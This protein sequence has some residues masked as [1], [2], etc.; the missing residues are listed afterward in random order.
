[1]N[2]I[3]FDNEGTTKSNR[4]IHT[5]SSFARKNLN[6]IQEI[7]TLKSLKAHSSIR[8]NLDSYL[9]FICLEGSGTVSAAGKIYDVKSGD[10]VFLDCRKHYE[11]TSS[12]SDPW[13]ISWIHFNGN[14]VKACFPLFNEGNKTVPVFTPADGIKDFEDCMKELW[15]IVSSEKKSVMDEIRS[16]NI[17]SN[18]VYK[19]MSCVVEEN[20]LTIDNENDLES[21][22]Y[23]SLRESVNE[24][25]EEDSL[26]RVL[27]IQYGL[28]EDKLSSLFEKK[29]G[30]S[31]G[32]YILNRRFN[33]AKELLRFT[34]KPIEEIIVESG[35]KD[36][37]RFKQLFMD[38]EEMTPEDY[39]KKWAQWIKS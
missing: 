8:E 34:I 35:I 39:R 32:D 38:N 25:C 19:A 3:V 15:D 14:V 10:V 30:I 1:M 31:I 28:E 12:D 2:E 4:K 22:D 6:Y 11:H 18:I 26:L 29:Y 24:H 23:A 5:P 13:K 33:K 36:P 21:D 20:E 27:S 9:M 17:L 16:D 37:D 7:G